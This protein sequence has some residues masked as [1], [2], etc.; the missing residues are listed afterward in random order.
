[1]NFARKLGG[2]VVILSSNFTQRGSPAI[3]NKFSR[4]EMAI[5]SGADLVIELPFL[6]ACSAGQDF[7]GGAVDLIAKT[8][9]ADSIIF[10]MEDIN[11]DVDSLIAK[12][13]NNSQEYSELL[14]NELDRGASFSKANSIAMG[15]IYPDSGEFISRPNNLLALSYIM[16]IKEN[17][18][19]LQIIPFERRGDYSSKKI[20][21]DLSK[22][23]YMLPESSQKILSESEIAD[24]SKL[25]PL[26]QNIF[27]RSESQELRKIY[28]ID[29]GIENL[30][31]KQWRQAKNLD[32]FIGRCVCARYTRAHIRRRLIYILLGLERTH[33]IRALREGVQYAR[34]LAFNSRGRDILRE[35][36]KISRIKII[37][38]LKDVHNKNNNET[39]EYFAMIENKASLLYELLLN[40][41]DM[42]RESQRV[43]QF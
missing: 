29:E 22:N 31:I 2:V 5:K 19:N 27:I 7:A 39:G 11:F 4:A 18:Y 14:K 43:L 38:R 37:T 41:P 28:G 1:M 6:Y 25:W 34:V 33:T 12:I 40:S 15:K 35:H 24:E 23:L 13:F 20:R 9:L 16:G 36:K 30:F 3:I 10:G 21:G 17:N 42:S 8:G 26:L 32:D